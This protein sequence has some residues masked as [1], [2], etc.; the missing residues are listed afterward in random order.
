VAFFRLHYADVAGSQLSH[1]GEAV[2]LLETFFNQSTAGDA[3]YPAIKPEGQ[4]AANMRIHGDHNHPHRKLIG[5]RI[6]K[7]GGH[8]SQVS[9]NN[10]HDEISLN[11]QSIIAGKD[12]SS[13]LFSFFRN[14][15]FLK[16]SNQ[17]TNVADIIEKYSIAISLPLT[18]SINRHNE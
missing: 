17:G 7:L 16:R 6:S 12:F 11:I 4:A 14:T 2:T 15:V 5:N 3:V 18:I 10:G 9:G 1:A 8:F 13:V